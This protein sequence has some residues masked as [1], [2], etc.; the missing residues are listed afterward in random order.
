[1]SKIIGIDLGTTNSCVAI[2]E[3]N[4]PRVLENS[5]GDRTTP[6]IVAYTSNNEVLIGKPAKRQSITNPKNTLFAIKR[7]IGRKYDDTEIQKDINLMPYKIIKS[8]NGDAWIEINN[9]KIA[10]P[11]I[12]AEI[13]KKMKKTAEDYL[14]ESV[15]EAVITVPAYFNDTQ[16]Q[17]TK[18]A[19]KIAGLEVKRII[20]EPTA[21][22]LAYGLDKK[23][24]N[25]IIAVYDLGGGTFDISIIEI[26]DVDGEK[27]F[28]VLS[29]NGDTHLGGEDFDNN[30]IRY[31]VNEFKKD[32]NID[33]YNDPLAMQRLKDSSEKAKIELSSSQQ[34]EIN[35]PYITANESGPKHMNYKITRSKLE[36]LVENLVNKTI[37]PVKLAL[38]DANISISDVKDII[39]VGGQTR[40]PLVQKIVSEFFNKEVRKD[41]NPDEAVAIGAAIQGGVLSGNVKDLLLLDVTPLSLGIETMGGIMT[42]L[43]PKNTTIPTKHSQVF[44]T[45]EDNQSAVTIH[46]LQGERK[47]S[48]DNKSLGQFNL[49]GITPSMRGI[50]QIEV[51]FDIDSDGILH[52]SAKDKNSGKEQKITIQASSGLSDSEI[53]NMIHEAEVNSELDKKFEELTQLKNQADQIIHGTKKQLNEVKDIIS[54]EEKENIEKHVQELENSLKE[55]DKNNIENK[56]KSLIQVS[57]KLFELS[58]K[59]NKE[60]NEDNKI[61]SN[62]ETIDADFE[63]IKED[64]KS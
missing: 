24:E 55:E 22:A 39:L 42:T 30:I 64:K 34:T 3:G 4:K 43:I 16:R 10:P 59:N 37:D 29:T 44:S 25:S 20:N 13:L 49:D 18:D 26:D 5:E 32:N 54:S 12:S 35:L 36:S 50:P 40:M 61:N 46:V 8:D 41:V 38:K 7:L 45:A 23:T 2:I 58:K 48:I 31:L 9:K 57:S 52:V 11:Q 33:L 47:K 27:T 63:E 14:N 17:A 15:S 62:N 56:I 6:S 1:M 21:A 51:T 53:K 60:V 19:G 28:E